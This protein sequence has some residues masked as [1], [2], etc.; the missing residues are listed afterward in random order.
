[1]IAIGGGSVI[2]AGKAISAMLPINEPVEWYLEVV[3]HKS[4]PGTKIPFIAVPTTSGTGSE[5]TK[6]AVIS[7]PG[8]AGYKR[9]LRHD[10]FVPDI[11]VVDPTLT[12]SCP[13][14]VTAACGMDAF[15]Q[16]LESYVS[17]KSTAMSDA[18][19]LDGMKAIL[20]SLDDAY[21]KNTIEAR[22]DMSYAAMLSG[23]TLANAGLGLVHGYASSVGGF[24]DIPHGVVCG[25]M[26]AVTTAKT[27][28]HLRN[29][30][31]NAEGLKRY[32]NVGRLITN[33]AETKENE[34]LDELVKQLNDWTVSLRMPRLSS[35]GVQASDLEKIAK[36]TDNK[37]N[38]V[39]LS[40]NEI[41]EILHERL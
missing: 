21:H 18:L 14:S 20:R 27:I 30:Q 11:A 16:L 4:H 39:K 3:G 22:S 8:A 38:P 5:A 31:S 40:Q 1:V 6:N 12:L 29:T 41:L 37:N 24:F 33:N 36:I 35:Y 15:T 10:N 23:I 13:P 2:D 32:S 19:A 34:A 7:K 17:S 25:T 28:Q 26:L 9:S